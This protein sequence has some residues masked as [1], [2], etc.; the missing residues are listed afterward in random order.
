LTEVARPAAAETESGF[1]HDQDQSH[2]AAPEGR[3][4]PPFEGAALRNGL[5]L[6]LARAGALLDHHE[7][8]L[9]WV[10]A[11]VLF[12]VLFSLAMGRYHTLMA[13]YDLGYFRQSAWLIAEGREPFVTVRGLHL[14]GDHANLAFYPMAWLTAVLPPVPTLLGIQAGALA[15]TV[16]PL[17][18]FARRVAGLSLPAS[19]ALLLAYALY[20]AMTN[21]NLFDFHPEAIAV[22]LLTAATYWSATRRWLPYAVAVGI[23]L[24][25]RE[26][27]GLVISALGVLCILEG[28]RRA[29][30]L[31]IVAGVAWIVIATRF[32][33]PAFAGGEFVQAAVR[34]PQYGE[35]MA[36]VLFGMLTHPRQ[37]VSDLVTREN[38]GVVIALFGPV[39]FLCLAA[40][41]YLLPGLPLQLLYLVSNVGAA[42]TIGA[43]YTVG[44]IPFVFLATAMVLGR[45]ERKDADMFLPKLI[46]PATLLFFVQLSSASVLHAPWRWA[47]RDDVDKATLAAAR[48]VP[49]D[50]PVSTSTGLWPVIAD[51]EDLYYFPMPFERYAP[52][53]DPK[54]LERRRS[55]VRYIVVDTVGVNQWGPEF[56]VALDR[57]V[58]EQGFT[59]IFDREGVLVFR[60]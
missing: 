60:R 27:M 37:V 34:Y 5:R 53:G 35:T 58:A 9:P 39:A 17:Y 29:G 3:R 14:L 13:T 31:T 52:S 50:A 25:C 47:T 28:N 19:A 6:R 8:L 40:P 55:E 48:L 36:E 43:Q 22:P 51:R 33:Q 2:E 7:R 4:R 10:V 49:R 44:I 54:P 56:Q 46:L 41:R 20:P 59:R 12:V 24:A 45:R 21:V 1:T 32:I 23:V 16:V 18:S 42:H 26:D 15:I 11:G 38:L 30:I 57:I